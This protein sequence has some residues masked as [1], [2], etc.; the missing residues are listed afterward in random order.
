MS[1]DA[2][3]ESASGLPPDTLPELIQDI[4]EDT[5]SNIVLQTALSCH[6]SEKLLRMQSAATQAE[7][8]ALAALEP[9]SQKAGATSQPAIPVAETS[10]AKYENGRVLLKG[11]PLKTTPEIICPHCKLPR[12]M[13]PIMG[14]GMQNPDLTKE[15]CMLYPWV[16]RSGHDVYGN[17][18]PTDMAKSKKERE[19]IKQ[20]QKNADKESVGT[21]GSQDTEMTGDTKEIKLNTGGKPASY[22]PWHTCPNCKR[23]LLIT[24]FAQHLE[25][26]LGI[27]GRQS[28]RN[29]MAKLVGQNG[30]GSGLGNTPLGSRMGTPNPGSQ[31]DS[32][33][34]AKGKGISPIKKFAQA[35]D[36]AD[37]L[38]DE[39]PERKKK[40][41]SSYIKK[42]DREKGGNSGSLK[43]K[44]KTGRP[45]NERKASETSERSE[46]K[47]ERDGEDGDEPRKK[48]SQAQLGGKERASASAEPAD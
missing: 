8:I 45:E 48:K 13:H 35:E 47:R 17:P 25:K 11:N 38:G 27:S 24:R 12:L 34:K 39:T 15:Y 43:V 7:S 42:A 18:F 30:T 37:E 6:R 4:L 46:G 33:S 14:K 5:L 16:Q 29:A 2:A 10:A 1:E 31:G 22:I 20:Q 19:L 26:C 32:I 28:S 21:P 40:K 23:S 3:G 44:L 36:D 9:A 41:K